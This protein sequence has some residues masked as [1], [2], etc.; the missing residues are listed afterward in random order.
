MLRHL[1]YNCAQ[2]LMAECLL[3]ISPRYLCFHRNQQLERDQ[4][5]PRH[6]RCCRQDFP[7]CGLSCPFGTIP[8]FMAVLNI[9]FTPTSCS[10][11]HW[12]SSLH[13]VYSP[14]GLPT[15]SSA[16]ISAIFDG[17]VHFRVCLWSVLCLCAIMMCLCASKREDL[18]WRYVMDREGK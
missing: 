14:C 4:I 8:L 2:K 3:Q 16:S 17:V 15:P 18:L 5:Y 6:L 9:C 12:R 7:V 1:R 10:G 13:S 11:V